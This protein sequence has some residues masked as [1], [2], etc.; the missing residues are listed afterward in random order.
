MRGAAE[1]RFVGPPGWRSLPVVS[2]FLI[3]L[4]VGGY[5]AR[6]A[7]PGFLDLVAV[8][9]A[10][11]T[12]QLQL[13]R[14][15][16]YPAGVVG[17]WNVVMDVLLLWSMAPELESV[18]GKA[19]LLRFVLAAVLFA[20][21]VGI[22]IALLL[23]RRAAGIEV[24]YSGFGGLVTTVIAA[25]A[26]RNPSGETM[27]FGL[28]PMTRTMFAA[29]A[30]VVVFFAT[31]EQTR[32]LPLLGYLLGGLPIAW[33]FTRGGRGSGFSLRP[34]RLFRRGRLRVVRGG[35]YRVH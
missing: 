35:D 21:L 2:R 20:G 11:V 30:V 4:A 5:L 28:L 3:A 33:W 10:P 22:G 17:I 8:A 25:W 14:L 9:P 13:W 24:A 34:S 18:W 26:L 16:V 12:G 7:W 31:I 23:G 29:F 1:I 32:S 15:L 27:F 19:R 6:L